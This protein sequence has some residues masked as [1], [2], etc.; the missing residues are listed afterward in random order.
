[1]RI[2]T[3]VARMP[4]PDGS[5]Y[6]PLSGAL[7]DER[8]SPFVKGRGRGN[9][10]ILVEVSGE[11]AGRDIVAMQLAEAMRE[12]Y[13]SWQGS[14]T[15]GLQQAIS[16][17]NYLL[18]KE[19]RNALPGERR[20]AGI[21]CA[22][23]RHD[24][25][26]V[27]QAGL[28]TAYLLQQGKLFRFPENPSLTADLPVEETE[29]IAV[30][31]RREAHISLFH[32]P[33][34]AGDTLLLVESEAGRHITEAAWLEILSGEPVEAVLESVAARARY[35]DFWA[36]VVRF[37]GEEA[38]R[39]VALSLAPPDAAPSA[40]APE[41]TGPAL[42]EQ[43]AGLTA[44]LR[45]GERLKKAGKAVLAVLTGLGV[46][47][48]TLVRRLI[49]GQ[50][51]G[52]GQTKTEAPIKTTSPSRRKAAQ[53]SSAFVQKTLTVIAI[54]IPLIVAIIVLGTYLQRGQGQRSELEALWQEAN[55]RWQETQA[56]SDQVVV[57]EL[58][59]E[60]E[61][62][63]DQLLE[64][65]P[66]HADAI[67]LRKRVQTWLDEI[68]QVRRIKWIADLKTY[69]ADADLSRVV[70]EGAHIFVMDR[71]A[72]TVYHHQMDEYRQSLKPD[73][74]D[75]ILVRKGEQVGNILVGDLVDM[76]WMPAGTDRQKANLLI[77]ERGGRLIEYDPATGERVALD[78]SNT[79][80]QYPKLVG[81]YYGR[82]Y[83]LDPTANQIWRYYPTPD[84]YSAP[85][86][87]WL[88]T[89]V[90]LAGVVD[91][92]IGNSIYLL[93]ADGKM[94][95]LSTGEPD[96]FDISDWDRPP[97]SPIALFTSPPENTQWVYVADR[98]NKRIVQV[99][100]DGHF[101]HQ[102]RLSDDI[103]QGDGD[104]LGAVTSLFVDEI[105]GHAYFLSGQKLYMVILPN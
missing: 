74:R 90:D 16:K 66:D 54:A 71:N 46:G 45:L 72:G 23:L 98:G 29:I 85:P 62:L 1:M 41:S 49:P 65:Q 73:S 64:R 43:L 96:T 42:G 99:G 3:V 52:S 102:Y 34:G 78:V 9:L 61:G 67:H 20:S 21:S 47:L 7:V 95:K 25:L 8:T 91:M 12:V 104:P 18:F 14:V 50:T 11:E 59:V 38:G 24:D 79:A 75:T 100:K 77:L 26:F 93:Y 37:V 13:Y 17:A 32:T 84:G 10:Y 58:L 88:Q 101:K 81:S 31:S 4:L 48:W 86:D 56:T 27:A 44:Q 28:A 60:A 83:L 2:H 40:T 30:G 6:E 19:N 76:T 68:D 105:S 15:A 87:E 70:V 5:H 53:E 80:W 82:F 92:A 55:A 63:L 89:Q 57:R 22:V 35:A 97:N 94:R 103:P 39:A 36:V 33:I 69:P 51:P